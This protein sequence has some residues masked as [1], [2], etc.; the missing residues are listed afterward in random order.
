[1]NNYHFTGNLK[2]TLDAG[3]ESSRHCNPQWHTSGSRQEEFI[4][5]E[6]V[7]GKD[8]V[9]SLGHQCL[10]DLWQIQIH[11]RHFNNLQGTYN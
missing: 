7:V 4:I 11:I 10:H 3:G 5:H 8:C 9:V 2:T 6:D 1:M